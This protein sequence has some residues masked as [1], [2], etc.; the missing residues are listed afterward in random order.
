MARGRRGEESRDGGGRG[1][2]LG[3]T[4]WGSVVLRSF[5]ARQFRLIPKL[6]RTFFLRKGTEGYVVVIIDEHCHTKDVRRVR[7]T[8]RH[9]Q[10]LRE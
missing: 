5:G 2:V 7:I 8:A 3:N 10:V 6:R 9:L 1:P 4:N